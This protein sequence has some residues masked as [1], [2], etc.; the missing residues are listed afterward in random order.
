MRRCTKD[1]GGG[2][3][4]EE[5]D[6]ICDDD[7]DADDAADDADDAEDDDDGSG[8]RSGLCD[9]NEL[10]MVGEIPPPTHAAEDAL[11][12]DADADKDESVDGERN[13]TVSVMPEC[14][15]VVVAVIKPGDQGRGCAHSSGAV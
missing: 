10:R 12:A 4:A 5:D 8:T 15:F 1:G 13:S 14:S 11:D 7:E 3:A 9:R 6:G 2:N